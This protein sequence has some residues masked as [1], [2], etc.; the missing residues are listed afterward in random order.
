MVHDVALFIAT[1]SESP[2]TVSIADHWRQAIDYEK[3]FGPDVVSSKLSVTNKKHSV[4]ECILLSKQAYKP[5]S[6]LSN[7]E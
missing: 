6:V 5:N 1:L 4:N 3:R 2:H 7:T